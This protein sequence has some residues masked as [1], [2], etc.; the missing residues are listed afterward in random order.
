MPWMGRLNS[1]ELVIL[2]QSQHQQKQIWTKTKSVFG[3]VS[4]VVCP[5]VL[6][7]FGNEKGA[8]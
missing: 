4:L 8:L 5:S 1:I 2:H 6:I 3:Y 7:A